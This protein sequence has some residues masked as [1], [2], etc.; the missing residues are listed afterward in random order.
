MLI[1]AREVADDTTIDADICVIGAGAAGLTIARELAGTGTST[2]LLES[3]GFEYDSGT[4]ALYRGRLVGLPL[5]PQTPVGIDSPRL[6]FFGG[7]TNHWAGFCRP[8]EPAYLAER[9]HVPSSGW[10]IDRAELDRFY[11]RAHD[12]LGLADFR[13]DWQSWERQGVLPT[14]LLDTDTT[15]AVATQITTTPMLGTVHRDVVVDAPNVRVFLWANAV[16]LGL[17]GDGGSIDQVD[18]RTL[19]GRSFRVRARVVVLATG[20]LEVPRLL[21]ASNDVRPAGVGNGNGLVGRYFAEHLA[22]IGGVVV[23]SSS[24]GAFNG[25]LWTEHD[26]IVGGVARTV[27]FQSVN[28]ISEGTAVDQGLLGSEL[29]L[30]TVTAAD[31]PDFRDVFP[32]LD[33]GMDLL[34]AEGRPAQS[35]AL[36]R[37]LCE[38]EPNPSSRVTLIR[39]RDPLGMPRASL[40]WRITGDDRR[41]ILRSL[42]L[43]GNEIARSG[44][45]R[46]KID[47]RPG[48]VDNDPWD[49]RLDFPVNTGSHHMGTARMHRSPRQGVVDEHCRVH[50]VV[51]LYVAG[52]AVF[53][54]TGP[55][56][57]TVT[58]VALALRLA[59]HLQ[60]QTIAP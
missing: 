49:G 4:Q 9:P 58:I 10:P 17:A 29:T 41:S 52:S 57:P 1:D 27:G 20:G 54:T 15:P 53:P 28:V 60:S 33:E 48:L 13:Y 7:T 44:I 55:Q 23:S 14:P 59:D 37:M 56:P 42:E 12:V 31:D 22:V 47:L 45:G 8:F 43:Y 50:D 5:D 2:V 36:V 21:L 24:T 6:R 35:F 34:A 38:Q 51:N 39:A 40:D 18:V 46:L 16:R 11:P 30:L 32:G 3:G 19:T 25:H 26:I